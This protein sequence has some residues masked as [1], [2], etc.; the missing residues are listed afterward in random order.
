MAKLDRLDKVE[1]EI[2]RK[3]ANPLNQEASQVQHKERQDMAAQASLEDKAI[4][5]KPN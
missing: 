2:S 1:Q 3:E 5:E 4:N